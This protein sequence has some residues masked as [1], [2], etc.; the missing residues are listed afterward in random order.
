MKLTQT[1]KTFI[2]IGTITKTEGVAALWLKEMDLEHPHNKF[3]IPDEQSVVFWSPN[4]ASLMSLDMATGET[5]WQTAV[6]AGG[7]A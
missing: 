2:G 1:A 6:R 5:I 7:I 3:F 4:T